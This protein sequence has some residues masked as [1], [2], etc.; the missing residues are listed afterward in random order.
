M[1]RTF[2]ALLVILILAAGAFVASAAWPVIWSVGEIKTFDPTV[3][4]LVLKQGL[5]QMTFALSPNASIVDG[6]VPLR[7]ADLLKNVGRRVKV[8][9]AIVNEVRVADRVEIRAR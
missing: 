1:R 7:P 8:R 3:R 2:I 5:H 6:L 9:Y 4:S